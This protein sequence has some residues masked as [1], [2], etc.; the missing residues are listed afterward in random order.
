MVYNGCGYFFRWCPIYPKWDIYQPL[1]SGSSLLQQRTEKIKFGNWVSAKM[2]MIFGDIDHHQFFGCL[3]F[4][5]SHGVN[6]YHSR[7]ISCNREMLRSKPW[8]WELQLSHKREIWW[9]LELLAYLEILIS[10]QLGHF[11]FLSYWWIEDDE[12]HYETLTLLRV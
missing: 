2:A 1:F 3:I 5:Q 10:Q 7:V 6:S 9:G 11:F 4:R 12:E 8:A